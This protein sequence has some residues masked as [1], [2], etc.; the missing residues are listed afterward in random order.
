MVLL[1]GIIKSN[2]PVPSFEND[3]EVGKVVT[4]LPLTS[5]KRTWVPV[6]SPSSDTTRPVT[7]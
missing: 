5:P 4:V 6:A 2:V 7:L 3:A 1:T